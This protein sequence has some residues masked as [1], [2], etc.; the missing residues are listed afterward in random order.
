[1]FSQGIRKL[2]Q[3]DGGSLFTNF[4]CTLSSIVVN[5]AVVGHHIMHITVIKQRQ[6][7]GGI[8]QT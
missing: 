8:Q 3:H 2:E 1:M 4:D 7:K 5:L 6:D